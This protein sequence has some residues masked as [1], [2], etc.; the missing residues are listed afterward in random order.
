M[1]VPSLLYTTEKSFS[2][3]F[4]TWHHKCSIQP[5]YMGGTKLIRNHEHHGARQERCHSEEKRFRYKSV[6]LCSQLFNLCY[7]IFNYIE[8]I[9]KTFILLY[10]PL[11][12]L[13]LLLIIN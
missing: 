4:C 5:A 10:N 11:A 7:T 9:L 13:V 2:Y 1:P 12:V 6:E 3:L 8:L